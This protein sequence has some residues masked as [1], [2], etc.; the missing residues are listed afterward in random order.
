LSSRKRVVLIILGPTAVGKSA[1]AVDL[2]LRFEGEVINGDSMQVYRGFDIGTDKPSAQDRRRV[3]HHG[4]DVADPE[5]QFS[6]ADFARLAAEAASSILERGRLPIVVGGSGLYLKALVDGLFP[7]P[8]RDEEI[9]RGLRREADALGWE[10]LYGRLVQMDP[11]YARKISPRDKVRVIRAL[12]VMALTGIPLSAHFRRTESAL[13]DVQT[14]KIGLKL[15]RKELHQRIEARV[16]RMFEE[17]LVDEVRTL[18]GRNVP[19]SAPAFQA[20]GY[21]HVL[22]CINNEASLDQAIALTKQD[23]RQF[24]KRQMTWFRKMT[25]VAWF[26]AHD[27]RTVADYVQ[28]R[29]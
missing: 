2:A 25:G 21:G 14:A 7:G 16:D 1:L 4:L 29:L 28:S 6:A 3:P 13:K 22:R 24:A 12:E 23:T 19:A 20:L 10:S 18:L 9:R 17:G 15:E 8:G 5:Q 26:D 27:F 11:D